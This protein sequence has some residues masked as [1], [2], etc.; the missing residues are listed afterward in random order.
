MI[1]II[2]VVCYYV[3]KLFENIISLYQFGYSIE[4]IANELR[5][6]KIK[7]RMILITFNL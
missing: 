1:Y 2:N 6:S 4:N 7:V 5:I 3:G